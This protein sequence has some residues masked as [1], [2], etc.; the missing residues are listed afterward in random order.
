LQANTALFSPFLHLWSVFI[1]AKKFK[2]VIILGA[3]MSPVSHIKKPS[4]ILSTTFKIN[5]FRNSC[6]QTK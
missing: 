6:A 3:V 5:R 4:L 1:I 2:S